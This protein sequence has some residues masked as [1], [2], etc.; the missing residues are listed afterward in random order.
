MER[1]EEQLKAHLIATNDEFRDLFA[2]HHDWD[3]KLV[4]LESKDR[5]SYDEQMEETRLK[6]LKLRAKDRMTQILQ[7]AAVVAS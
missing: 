2:K 5:L 4:E 3:E 1:N 7:Q 6:K